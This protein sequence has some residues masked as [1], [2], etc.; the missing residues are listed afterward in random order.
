MKK[1]MGPHKGSIITACQPN[2]VNDPGPTAAA[3]LADT[4]EEHPGAVEIPAA[5]CGPGNQSDVTGFLERR[6]TSERALAIPAAAEPKPA[7]AKVRRLPAFL[8]SDFQL[9]FFVSLACSCLV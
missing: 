9:L 1:P 4:A 8:L 5:C 2:R 6:S 3:T 7:R